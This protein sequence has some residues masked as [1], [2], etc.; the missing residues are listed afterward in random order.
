MPYLL[1]WMLYGYADYSYLHKTTFNTISSILSIAPSETTESIN[2]FLVDLLRGL[3]K[4]FE[5]Y[6][7]IY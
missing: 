4:D 7:F 6:P 5:G 3:V 2:D 1:F